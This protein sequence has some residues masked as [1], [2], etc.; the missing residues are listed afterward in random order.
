VRA[1]A[2][3]RIVLAR[4]KRDPKPAVQARDDL[5]ALLATVDR[6]RAPSDWA[7]ASL[8]YANAQ[9]AAGSLTKDAAAVEAGRTLLE[10]VRKTAG[11]R[12]GPIIEDR[13][14]ESISAVPTV[15]AG[16]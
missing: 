11:T 9:V 7:W 3:A 4:L 13:V 5:K 2:Q 8:H 10:E 14:A 1:L 16:P 12:L 15:R 6:E